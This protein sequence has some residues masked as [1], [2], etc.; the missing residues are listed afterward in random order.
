VPLLHN[1]FYADGGIASQH[2]C[3]DVNCL[4]GCLKRM[5]VIRHRPP[6][7]RSPASN[8]RMMN[9]PTCLANADPRADRGLR[10]VPKHE[11]T[12]AGT[13][14]VFS[15]QKP[16]FFS[17]LAQLVSELAPASEISIDVVEFGQKKRAVDAGDWLTAQPAT[18]ARRVAPPATT[19]D[20][21]E[22]AAAEEVMRPIIGRDG[23]ILGRAALWPSTSFREHTAVLTAGDA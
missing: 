1:G 17:S 15:P 16:S 7:P 6:S 21:N 11:P 14:D 3:G 19:I 20:Q 22:R 9:A 4:T 12:A 2:P 5:Q 23:N 8:R 10:F 18:I 13:L